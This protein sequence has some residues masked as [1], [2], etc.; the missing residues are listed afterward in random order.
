VVQVVESDPS[1]PEQFRRTRTQL[2][3][4]L[5]ELAISVDHIGSTSV[6]GLAAK[7]TI[8]VLVVVDE[9][10]E[11]LDR[12]DP[13]AAL[14]FQYRPEAWP[15]PRHHLFFRRVVDGRRTDHLHVVPVDSDEIGD[16]LTLRDYLRRHPGEADD[17]EQHKR[18]LVAD[19]GGE[20][21]AY[22]ERKAVY[23][24]DLL[25]RARSWDASGNR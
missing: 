23:V 22:V 20:R 19:T 25:T 21:D 6:P 7:P 9:T 8:D 2:V 18:R 1:W 15:D 5:G 16:Y 17:Y 14:G 13:L 3:G 4:C 11:V 24:D 12:L 10:A